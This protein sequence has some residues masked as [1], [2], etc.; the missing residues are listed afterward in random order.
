M[1]SVFIS[2]SHQDQGLRS[3]L[4]KHLA[5]LKR[6]GHVDIW[7]D[8]CIRPGEAFDT[9][10]NAALSTSDIVLLLISSDFIHSDYCFG[11]EMTEAMARSARGESVVIPVILRPCDWMT[12][13]FGKLKALPTDGLAIV[14]WPTLDDGYLDVVKQ[15]RALLTKDAGAKPAAKTSSSRPSQVQPGALS[16]EPAVPPAQQGASNFVGQA[17]AKR[18]SNLS[19][20][21]KFTDLERSEF[22]QEGFNEIRSY[23]ERSLSELQAR[24]EHI[25]TKHTVITSQAFTATIF[26]QGKKVAGCGI[27]I[28]GGF[29]ANGISYSGSDDPHVNSINESLS[30]GDD[31]YNLGWKTMMGGMGGRGE[32]LMTHDGAASHL[33]DMFVSRL[34]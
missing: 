25:K 34:Q 5:L 33:W 8:H 20:P 21:K 30:I 2:Y 18:S 11:V 12:A 23:F 27:K 1:A 10:I 9:A 13:P 16:G 15:L 3:Q 19:L 31:K 22:M 14:K 17:P 29:G 26:D 32:A 24:N 28:G 4:D 6:E 7:T